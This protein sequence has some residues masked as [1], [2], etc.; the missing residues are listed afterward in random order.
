MKSKRRVK[1]KRGGS[2]NRRKSE[3]LKT[4]PGG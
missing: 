3:K 2:G 1:S 4:K